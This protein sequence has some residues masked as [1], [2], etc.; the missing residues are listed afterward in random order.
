M[1]SSSSREG[2]VTWCNDSVEDIYGYSKDEL[3]GNDVHFPYSHNASPLELNRRVTAAIKKKGRFC[4]TAKIKKKDGS[5]VDIEYT[6]SQIQGRYPL[7]LV[8]VVRDITERKRAEEDR[9]KMEQQLQLAGRLAAVGELAAG[10]A[11]ELNNPLAAVLGLSQLLTQ[12]DNL[13]EDIKSDVETIYGEAQRA[14]KITKNLL[15]F[16]RRHK[17][18]KRLI[19]INDA[20][21]QSLDLHAYQMRASNIEISVGLDPNLPKTM[22]DFQQMQQVFIN[23]V[24]NARQAMTEA[25]GRGKLLV[26][27]QCADGMIQVIFTDDGPGILEDDLKRIFDPFF[28]TKE[29][30]QGAGLGLSICYGLLQ[31]HG[32]HIF[33]TSIPG[34]GATFVLEMPIISE[35]QYRI[36]QTDLIVNRE[37]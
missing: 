33:A 30:G 29:V 11:H 15:S 19:S 24:T 26:Q 8:A 4:D 37:V 23:I 35:E 32:G 2:V 20:V 9:R 31:E 10:V 16:A 34:E 14:A 5:A 27:T 1:E 6:I 13:E 25:H 17:P 3:V 28:T 12:M 7:E 21:A 18:E 22:A 36:E